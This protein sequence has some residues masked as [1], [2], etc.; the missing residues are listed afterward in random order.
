[1]KTVYIALGSNLGDRAAH[2]DEAR[3]R[4]EQQG[5]K[6]ARVS[7]IFETAPRERINQ[8]WFLN[9]VVE[10][11]TALA[12]RSLL[13]RLLRIEREMG[14]RRLI[15]N[16]PRVIDLD[17]VLYGDLIIAAE[18]L[19]I[20]H[21]RMGERRFVLEPLSELVPGL[22]HPESG[23]AIRDLLIQVSAQTARRWQPKITPAGATASAPE[24]S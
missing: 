1:M 9:Q 15:A 17:I 10:A 19:R 8:P 13:S 18:G 4:M 21:P 5:I 24:C 22:R 7:S 2:L 23:T 20:P 3:R 12:P 14:R 16:G 11:V 6:I